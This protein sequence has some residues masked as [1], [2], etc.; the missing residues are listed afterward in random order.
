MIG[1]SVSELIEALYENAEIEI[2]YRHHRYLISAWLEESGNYAIEVY[3][4]QK[5]SKTLFSYLGMDRRNV[6]EAFEDARIFDNQTIYQ[7]ESEIDV[8]YG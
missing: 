6:V 1:K 5:D 7:V 8:I 4:I 3:F 2:I